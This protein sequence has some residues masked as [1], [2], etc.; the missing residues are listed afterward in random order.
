MGTPCKEKGQAETLILHRMGLLQEL[1][2]NACVAAFKTTN[3][4]ANLNA[5]VAQR[6]D[7]V[8]C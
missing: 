5:L 4:L 7:K 1:G 6:I 8:D 2:S 3:S